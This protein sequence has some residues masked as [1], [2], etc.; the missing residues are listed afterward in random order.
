MSNLEEL[1]KAK[2]FV[3]K[4]ARQ[5]LS[6][7]LRLAEGALLLVSA[8]SAVTDD[9]FDPD[10][11]I[12][13]VFES[14]TDHLPVGPGR[15]LWAQSVLPGLLAE[16]ASTEELYRADAEASCRRLIERFGDATI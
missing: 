12:F 3:V 1:S 7:E 11:L 13:V 10:F 14:E 2:A 9:D 5:I 8:R 16:L 15:D 6:G 4:T